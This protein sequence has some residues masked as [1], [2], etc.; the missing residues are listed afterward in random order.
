[1]SSGKDNLVA[2]VMSWIH[3]L[4]CEG[5]HATSTLL[6]GK[7]TTTGVL[8]HLKKH[9]NQVQIINGELEKVL[10]KAYKDKMQE[11]DVIELLDGSE[12]FGKCTGMDTSCVKPVAWMLVC[13]PNFMEA[14]CG[15]G[16][17]WPVRMKQFNTNRCSAL[18][19]PDMLLPLW[20]V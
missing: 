3:K 4:E 6:S 12:A 19:R 15:E 5:L 8:N 20:R 14:F 13:I 7:I 11:G 1:M 17:N 16:F 18:V 9:R 2:V 10:N